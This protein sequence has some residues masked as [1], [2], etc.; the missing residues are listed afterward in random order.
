MKALVLLLLAVAPPLLPDESAPQQ[1]AQLRVK[2]AGAIPP[3]SWS[4]AKQCGE[5][6]L[7]I[8]AQWRSSAHAMASF[9]NPLYRVSVDTIRAERSTTA[10]RMCASCHDLALLPSGA[11]DAKEISP[12]DERAHAGVTCTTCH[13]AVH[14]TRDGNGSATLRSDP[15]FP[16]TRE[17]ATLEKHKARVAST[18]LR[19]AEL[20]G[21]C[22][23]S[24]LEERTGNGSAFFGMDDY[25]AWQKSAY[26]GQGAERPE[27][28][29]RQDCKACHMAREPAV[30]GDVAA[31]KGTVPSHRFLGA[32][33]ALAAMRGDG[34]HLRRTQAFLERA[35]TIDLAAA[36]VNGGPWL[37]PATRAQPKPGDELELDVVLFNE[38]TGHRFPGGVLD[39]Q[40]TRVELVVT[41]ARGAPIAVSTE[42]EVRS[43]VVDAQGRPVQ[44]RQTHEFV[45]AVWNHTVAARDARVTRV[46]VAVPPA[47]EAAD[48]PLRV[49]AR[50]THRARS[51][52]L[53]AAA[54]AD[55]KSPRGQA[56]AAAA[57]RVTGWTIDGCAEQPLTVIDRTELVLDGS[58]APEDWRRAYR[59]GLGLSHALQEYLD[60]AEQAFEHARGLAKGRDLATVHWAL[61]YVAG[62]RGQLTRALEWLALAEQALGATAAIFKARG[63]AYGQVW[64]WTEAANQW[65]RAAALAPEDLS[66]WANLA[67]A[68]A[69][70][71]RYA[72]A[73]AAAQKGLE[74]FPRDGDCL[75]VQALALQHLG[76]PADRALDVALT[77]RTPDDGPRAKALC[78]A[79]VP[80]CAQRRDP[81]PRYEAKAPGAP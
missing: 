74:L 38:K 21:S 12:D 42:H 23:R 6:H 24:F 15:V 1:P 63:D 56:F 81:V 9:N 13:S 79:K 69:S 11:M 62:K 16:D 54:C 22:H 77:W 76:A 60:D 10:S 4:D 36:K 75:R 59:R 29:E 41:T 71:G 66:V 49:A 34:E 32:H 67:M 8:A 25:G 28:L 68:E 70:V 65:R 57:K 73:L 7:D 53:A 14:V 33:T 35:A 58:A 5:C 80:G 26:A 31:K 37:M 61:G 43:Q 18:A 27:H 2:G 40:D 44:R 46:R 39:N 52:E 50:L 55:A 47:L 17:D 51:A 64:Q 30:L 19:T 3:A 78:S 20:C 48:L 72:Q 45:T